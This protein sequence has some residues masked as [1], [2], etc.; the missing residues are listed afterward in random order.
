[1]KEDATGIGVGRVHCSDSILEGRLLDAGVLEHAHYIFEGAP[2]CVAA[3]QGSVPCQDEN[4][5]IFQPDYILHI[6]V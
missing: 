2:I 1:L 3:V 4:N 5:F 6:M